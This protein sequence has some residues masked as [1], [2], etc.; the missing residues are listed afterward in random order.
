MIGDPRNDSHTLPSGEAVAR[1]I[2]I[3]PLNAAQAGLVAMGGQGETPLWYHV[4]READAFAGG[5]RLGPVGGGIVTGV[6]FGLVAADSSSYLG[7]DLEW[8]P[9]KGLVELLDGCGHSS[10]A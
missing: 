10:V 3:A 7:N 1:L 4:L 8:R 6:R 5:R 9:Q 2:G